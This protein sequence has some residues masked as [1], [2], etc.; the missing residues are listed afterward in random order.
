MRRTIHLTGRRQIPTSAFDFEITDLDGRKVAYLS[1]RN[2]KVLEGYPASSVVKVKLVEN[3]L[4]ET[5]EYGPISKLSTVTELSQE[6]F[7]APSCQIRIVGRDGENSGKLLASTRP[8]TFKSDAETEGIL[9][10]QAAD[11]APR[12]WRLEIREQERP[13]LYV[14]KNIPNVSTWSKSDPVFAACIFPHVIE[15]VFST[16]LDERSRP[17]DGWMAEWL[18]WAD[19]MMPGAEAPFS[20]V[21]AHAKWIDSL[22]DTFA[23]KHKLAASVL[24]G[25]EVHQ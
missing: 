15:R 1:A 2:I 5:L 17:E 7:Q 19:S 10:F 11:T 16:V 14:D 22:I 3:K 25:M 6:S 4:V 8:W 21:E 20:D 23:A 9:L 13:I 18:D 12:L 24:R